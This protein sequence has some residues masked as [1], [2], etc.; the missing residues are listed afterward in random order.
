MIT[1]DEPGIYLE[2]RYGIRLENELLCRKGRKNEYGQFMY[3]ENLTYVT[4][5]LDAI[6]PEQMTEVERRRLN[7][8]HMNVYRTVSP[9]LHG[10]ELA[11]LKEATREI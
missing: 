6:V 2:G 4:F 3:I 5:D 7:E 9:F 8:Y 1:T 11:W 10:E